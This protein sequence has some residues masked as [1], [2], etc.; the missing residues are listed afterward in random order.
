MYYHVIQSHETFFK[1][2]S[3]KI[4]LPGVLQSQAEHLHDPEEQRLSLQV[5]QRPT[6]A[7]PEL[8]N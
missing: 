8:N 2:I 5:Y 6:A 4:Q 7:N 3:N 1:T